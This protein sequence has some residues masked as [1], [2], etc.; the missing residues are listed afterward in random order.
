MQSVAGLGACPFVIFDAGR[1][2]VGAKAAVSPELVKKKAENA[3]LQ[4]LR[5]LVAEYQVGAEK[6]DRQLRGILAANEK[7]AKRGDAAEVRIDQLRWLNARATA[8]IKDLQKLNQIA[9]DTIGKLKGDLVEANERI[10]GL[11][12]DLK[13]AKDA[14]AEIKAAL[15]V[16]KR[17]RDAIHAALR[18]TEREFEGA[19]R[20]M[21]ER[22]VGQDPMAAFDLI[23][24]SA[25]RDEGRYLNALMRQMLMVA[26]GRALE[27]SMQHARSFNKWDE[28]TRM[29]NGYVRASHA[30]GVPTDRRVME[31]FE[32]AARLSGNGWARDLGRDWV[33]TVG[34]AA[35]LGEDPDMQG[36]VMRNLLRYLGIR[37]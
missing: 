18:T 14:G 2:E 30:L 15:D 33:R 13:K 32:R 7:L 22:G 26:T 31:G 11:N 17:E 23:A 25:G 1:F 29:A 12:A 28:I 10:S 36:F 27:R 21:A 35:I 3:E 19:I 20:T 24:A 5:D 6:D 9:N 37:I 4:R 16:A 34:E 8:E